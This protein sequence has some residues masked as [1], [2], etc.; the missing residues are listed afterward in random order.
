[1][2]RMIVWLYKGIKIFYAMVFSHITSILTRLCFRLNGIQF[3]GKV[4]SSG[5]P[6]IHMSLNSVCVIGKNFS[7]GN[8]VVNNASGVKAKSKIEVRRGAE[9]IIGENVGITSVTIMC[10]DKIHIGDNVM[11][12]VGSHIFDTNFHNINPVDRIQKKDP[13]DTVRT[14]PIIIKDNVFIGAFSIILK[15]VTIGKNSV[16]A[17]GSV[18]TKSI[19]DNQIWGGNPAQF[20][21]EIE[22]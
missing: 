19:P 3:L 18:V 8:W 22:L 16:V 4:R 7:I 10:F 21:K 2:M 6:V 13:K 20:I 5:V 1:M 11:I 14:A 12:G 9:L 15:G 17:A